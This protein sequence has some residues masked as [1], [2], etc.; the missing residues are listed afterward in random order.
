[1][2]EQIITIYCFCCEVVQSVRHVED[3]Q[4]Q[5]SDAEVLTTA[6]VAALYFRGNYQAARAFLREYGYIRQMLSKE[7]FNR[8]LHRIDWLVIVCFERLGEC[9]KALNTEALYLLD[10]FPI[11]VCDNYRIGR[12]KLYPRDEAYRGKIVG[13]KR[14]FFGVRVHLLTTQAGQPVEVSLLPAHTHDIIGLDCLPL[15]LPV[16]ATLYADAAYNDAVRE[17]I[18]TEAGLVFQPMRRR[19]RRNQFPGWLQFLQS[20]FR[21]QIEVTGGLLEQLLPKSIHAVTAR[22]FELKVMLFVVALSLQF[23]W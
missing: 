8:R 15:D 3:P 2:D 12:N 16:G 4:C 7:R 19:N 21:K 20:H 1:M 22:G 5:M 14:Y 10:S 13:K 17:A 23:L 11:A 9:W 6:L 18:C